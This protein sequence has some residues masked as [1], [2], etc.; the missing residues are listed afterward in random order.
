MT[1]FSTI[2]SHFDDKK[3]SYFTFYQKPQKPI[4]AVIY[5]LPYGTHAK[6]I[7]E[8]LISLGFDV[9]SIKQMTINCQSSAEGTTSIN[10][11][12]SRM[13]KSKKNF[14]FI[15]HLQQCNQS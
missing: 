14:H 11:T 12:L 13:A 3:I 15:K 6:D 4:K 1:D 8:G 5:H 9:I 10:L 2:K 7:S